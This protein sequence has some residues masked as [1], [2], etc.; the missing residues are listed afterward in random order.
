[1]E[2][3]LS[4]AYWENR[5]QQGLTGWDRGE[6]HPALL[7]WITSEDLQP[8]RILVPG[9]GNGYEVV[10]LASRGFQVTAVDFAESPMN[11]LSNELNRLGLEAD[12][13][14]GDL[15]EYTPPAPFDVVYEQTCLCAILPSERQNYEAKVHELLK[16][17]GIFH[18]L[19]MQTSV[20]TTGPPFHCAIEEMV[21]LFESH[22]WTWDSNEPK[23]YEHPAGS[24]H[25]L[26]TRL[27][28]N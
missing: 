16:P 19:F 20:P 3:N 23:R 10:E 1:M 21:L 8:C 12:L 28:R 9:C 4:D 18:T 15:F 13:I 14:L 6:C 11:R 5:Y 2:A 26:A 17:A 27:I 7:D 24:I 25:E 22:R